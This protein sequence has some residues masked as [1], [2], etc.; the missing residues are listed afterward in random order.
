MNLSSTGRKLWCE[1]FK[2][3]QM[4]LYLKICILEAM[5]HHSGGLDEKKS[6]FFGKEL[7]NRGICIYIICLFCACG[8]SIW[9]ERFGGLC[10]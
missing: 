7:E 4:V 9:H 3:C 8:L 2:I 1:N 5:Y 10:C 6:D